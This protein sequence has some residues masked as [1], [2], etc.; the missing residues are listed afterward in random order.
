M[1]KFEKAEK[2]KIKNEGVLFI[3]RIDV[4][5]YKKGDIVS[6]ED[7]YKASTIRLDWLEKSD[8]LK[9]RK[10]IEIYKENLKKKITIDDKIEMI[11]KTKPKKEIIE[12]T[13][14]KYT[15]RK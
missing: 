6:W 7:R 1:D 2:E 8:N 12:T 15:K 3:A 4:D 10:I 11:E 5:N 13:K 9:D 14:R